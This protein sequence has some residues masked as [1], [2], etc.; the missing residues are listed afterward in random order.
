MKQLQA[1]LIFYFIVAAV[2]G[3][4]MWGISNSNY[5]GNMGLQLN[6]STIVAAPYKYELHFFSMDIFA[7]DTYI[8][9]PAKSNVIV[10]GMTGSLGS[11]KNFFDLYNTN[12]Q[13]AFAHV[14]I[15]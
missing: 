6:P 8:Y 4:E 7:E 12:L 13:S 10:K 3:Q 11:E 2:S 1:F 9:L 14:N 15:I 5:S